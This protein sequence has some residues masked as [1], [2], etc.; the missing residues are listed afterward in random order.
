MCGL[1]GLHSKVEHLESA[2]IS[3]DGAIVCSACKRGFTNSNQLLTHMQYMHVLD[4]YVCRICP[5]QFVN[6]NQVL[7]HYESRHC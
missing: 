3:I 7:L 1:D 5:A 4:F 6:I 2:H